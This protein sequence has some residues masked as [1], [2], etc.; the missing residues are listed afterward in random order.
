MTKNLGVTLL[1]A[2]HGPG[3]HML[4]MEFCVADDDDGRISGP[5]MVPERPKATRWQPF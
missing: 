1:P 4:F 5:V 3:R 2:R